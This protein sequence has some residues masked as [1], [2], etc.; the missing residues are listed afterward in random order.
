[1]KKLRVLETTAKEHKWCWKKKH[2]RNGFS[3]ESLGE[4]G[5]AD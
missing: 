3:Q 2:E 5:S 4:M 1:M